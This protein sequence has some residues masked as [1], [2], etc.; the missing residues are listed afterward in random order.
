MGEKSD[1]R[2][3]HGSDSRGKLGSFLSK[4]RI[5]L[6]GNSGPLLKWKSGLK[7]GDLSAPP[8]VSCVLLVLGEPD[9][10]SKQYQLSLYWNLGRM[11]HVIEYM[12]Y[13]QMLE[14]WQVVCG[15]FRCTSKQRSGLC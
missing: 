3:N 14:F 10:P 5:I 11:I 8:F 6:R 12:V 2:R 13:A 4:S 1:S 15:L 7:M 9:E